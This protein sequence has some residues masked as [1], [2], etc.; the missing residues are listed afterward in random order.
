[1]QLAQLRAMNGEL[2]VA[3][4]LYRQ[5]RG[6]VRELGEGMNAAGT[7]I[8]VAVVELM[9]GDLAL[10][11][12]EVRADLAVLER[13]GET[14]YRS[15]L[16]ALLSRLVRD[17][18]RD[19]EALELSKIAEGLASHDDVDS[20]ALWRSI[21][22]PIIARQGEYGLAEELARS[23]YEMVRETEA[24]T[25]RAETLSELG[26]VLKLAGKFA[27]ARQVMD[28]AVALF[29]EKGDIASVN[30]LAAWQS[31]VP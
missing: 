5:G 27:E 7:G 17:Q 14:F 20:Q 29:R 21:R 8:D 4:S 25:L 19:D 23:A 24:L 1:L 26:S 11:E 15:T 9:G 18:G 16:T 10:A 6:I 3:R 12:R 2:E 28:E 22:A 13:A 30:R 31:D